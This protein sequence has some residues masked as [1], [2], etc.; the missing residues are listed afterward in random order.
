MNP[1]TCFYWLHRRQRREDLFGVGEAAVIQTTT[2][3]QQF[4]YRPL[5]FLLAL[6]SNKIQQHLKQ[7]ELEKVA[8]VHVA[9]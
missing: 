8:V 5:I 6:N 1:I 4:P 2:S 7:D 9:P 3:L